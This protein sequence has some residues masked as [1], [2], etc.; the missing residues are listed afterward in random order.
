MPES[1]RPITLPG[2]Q[3]MKSKGEKIVVLT[4][5]DA[6]FAQVLE[7]AGVDVILIGDSL[8]NVIQGQPTT[9]SV[10]MEDMLYH[11]RCVVRG[12]KRPWSIADLPF[13]SYSTPQA[14]GENS[15]RLLRE[16]GV[17]M[18]KLEGGRQ[19]AEVVSFLVGQNIPVCA[20]L[21]LLPQS[22]H[23]L[24]GYHVQGTDEAAARILLE[25]ALILE[26]AGAGLLVL[27]CVPALLA[28]EVTRALRIPVIGIGAGH[29][30]DGQVLVLHDLLGLG[31][32]KRPRFVKDFLAETGNIAGAVRA[33]VD[34]VRS[35]QF[36]ADEHSY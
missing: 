31:F 24:G 32:G 3:A 17:Q 22:I 9:L 5:Y 2:L 28:E 33:Y 4:A 11:C 34:A 26:D 1:T 29:R 16:G 18:V 14:A 19:R 15:A 20:H 21:G 35:G 8:G 6:T 7:A 10:S 13:M 23:R 27:E 36:P 30:C 12:G 25:D